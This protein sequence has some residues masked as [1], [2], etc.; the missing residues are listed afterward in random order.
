MF[1][2]NEVKG[3]WKAVKAAFKL[4]NE[5]IDEENPQVDLF[6]HWLPRMMPPAAGSRT[7][8][9]RTACTPR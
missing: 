5:D 3:N 7:M 4:I 2:Q 6:L 9:T 8:P 1:K